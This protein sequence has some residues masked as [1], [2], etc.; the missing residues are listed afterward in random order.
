MSTHSQHEHTPAVRSLRSDIMF[1]IGIL[2]LLGLMWVAKDVLLLIYVS[3]LFAVV[4]NPAIEAVRRVHIGHWWPS[5][6][7]AILIIIVIAG[8]AIT[9]FLIFALPPV[10]ND[11]DTI[12]TNFPKRLGELI[13]KL[14]RVPSLG[15]LN[16][17]SL[18]DYFETAVGGAFGLFKGVADFLFALFSWIILTAYFILDGQ[19]TFYWVLSFFP[20]PQRGRLRST[21]MRAE[22]KIRHWL[23]GQAALMGILG[24]SAS[25]AFRLMHVK[26]SLLLGV[27][28][29]LLNIVP[30]AGPFTSFMLSSTVA[31]MDSWSK[32]LGVVGFYFLYQQIENAILIPRIMKYS[33]DLPALSVI[34]S[35]IIGGALA[36]VL[37]ALIAVP[38]AGI[39]GVVLD[40]YVVRFRSHGRRVEIEQ[41]AKMAVP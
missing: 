38:T 3:A 21:M 34:I 30:F 22:R 39:I 27:L 33:V 32:L 25:V 19:R 23:I 6:P 41:P 5:R 14:H 28:A 20:E 15:K 4:L 16:P 10:I 7:T 11:F 26:Y 40:E 35:L 18:Q 9:L 37:G 13:Q 1:T 29:G 24:V 8:L 17:G 12:S 2:L 31:A 36:G